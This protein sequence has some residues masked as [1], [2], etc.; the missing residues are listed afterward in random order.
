MA[1]LHDA[2]KSLTVKA[3][4]DLARKQLGAG[5]SRLKTKS[6][7]V[8][9]LAKGL[10]AA[11]ARGLLGKGAKARAAEEKPAAKKAASTATATAKPTPTA[12]AKAAPTATAKATPT[13]TKGGKAE[14]GSPGRG[15][16][17]G[18]IGG[19]PAGP[20]H[21]PPNQM[22][23]RLGELPDRYFDDSFV[24]LAVDPQTLF[25]YWDHAPE[26]V[27]A[28]AASLP[29]PRAVLSLHSEGQRVRELD[30]ALESRCF[31]VRGLPPGRS[32]H[33]EID[34]VG[35]DGRR[36]RVGRPSNPAALPPSGPSDIVDDR[37]VAFPWELVKGWHLAE[38]PAPGQASRDLA[39][40]ASKSG[41]SM[42]L[43][44]WLEGGALSGRMPR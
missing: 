13:A 17:S 23:E 10:D 15:A 34:F 27:R 6:Q 41:A 20:P 7:L 3:L 40:G 25:L 42:P 9:A 29:S 4:R 35:A 33:A 2:L 22:D 43:R 39:A 37:F 8:A 31:Y 11:A 1:D 24:A 12:K 19:R 32:Y 30:F 28:A 14:D 5:Y 38:R 21:G 16:G 44:P 18:G 26:T 36:Q